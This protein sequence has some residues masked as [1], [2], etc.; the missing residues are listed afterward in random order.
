MKDL[1]PLVD[2]YLKDSTVFI[3]ELKHIQLPETTRIF[4]ADAKSMYTNINTDAGLAA[5]EIS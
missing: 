3:N 4:T 2:S 1:L 5:V